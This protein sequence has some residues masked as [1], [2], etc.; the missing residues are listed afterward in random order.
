L[1]AVT[2]TLD[3]IG[4]GRAFSEWVGTFIGRQSRVVLLQGLESSERSVEGSWVV[5][6]EESLSLSRNY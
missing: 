3:V 6:L 4:E 2:L 5:L 1:P